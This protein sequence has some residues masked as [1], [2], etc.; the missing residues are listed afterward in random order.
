MCKLRKEV[1]M[2]ER[3]IVRTRRDRGVLWVA[4]DNPPINLLDLKLSTALDALS[5]QIEADGEIKVVVFE[6]AVKDYFLSHA[7]MRLLQ[8]ARDAGFYADLSQLSFYQQM[9]E[10][11]RTMPKVCIAKVDGRAR[12]GGAEFTLALDM[13]FVSPNARFSQMEV[14]L[15]I[16]PG[17]GGAQYLARKAGRSRAL[18]VCLG[19]ADVTGADAAAFGFA[20]RVLPAHALGR[21]VDDLA[22]RIASLPAEAVA[23]NKANI[24]A[25]ES[26][27]T[28]GLLD[29]HRAFAKL[30]ASEAFDRR[31]AAF[32]AAGGQTAKGE[33]G[34]PAAMTARLS[35]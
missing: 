25:A 14:L 20:N 22:L 19:G 16:N 21:F 7:D 2:A 23:L 10:R 31:V 35:G 6:S 12:G 5:R 9:L 3:Q 28:E 18:E 27:V 34:D 17:G 29:A 8:Q 11:F 4:I 1:T 13:V 30:V 32:L 24:V 26:G 15:G 33:L